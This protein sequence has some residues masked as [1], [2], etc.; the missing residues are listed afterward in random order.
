MIKAGRRII[1]TEGKLTGR[2]GEFLKSCSNV[3]PQYCRIKLDLLGREREN[4]CIMIL[5]KDIKVEDNEI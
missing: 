5:K 4:K 3:F 2:S 1:V